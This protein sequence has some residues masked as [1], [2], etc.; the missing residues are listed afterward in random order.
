MIMLMTS[1]NCVY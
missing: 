1:K